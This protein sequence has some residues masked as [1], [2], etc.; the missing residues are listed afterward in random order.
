MQ[1]HK[2]DIKFKNQLLDLYKKLNAY[3]ELSNCLKYLRD[4]KIKTC[5]LSNGSPALLNELVD[6]AKVKNLFDDI[7]SV[8]EIKVYKPDPRVYEMVTKK[9][10]CMPNEICFLSSNTWDIVGGGVY[11]FQTCWVDRFGK[12]FDRLD[13]QP[14]KI[15]KDLSELSKLF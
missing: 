6:H 5:I 1:T 3:P 13:Y 8:D 12:E 9:Y 11:G 2:I 10:K 14:N 4:K 15:I 7:L